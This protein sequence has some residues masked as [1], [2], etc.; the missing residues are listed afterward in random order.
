MKVLATGGAGYI[1][2][3]SVR[4]LLDSGHEVVVLDTLEKGHR[5]AVDP[6]ATFFE[7]SVGDAA[8]LD[9]A[10]RGCDAVLHMAG[11][12]EVAE[13]ERDP[14]RY[15]RN[16]VSEPL[17]MLDVMRR[18][19]ILRLVF[20]STAAVYGE[21]DTVPIPE[22]AALAPVNAYGLSK[23]MFEQALDCY[24]R[25]YGLKSIRLRYFNVAGSA[26]DG[27]LGEAHRP[28]SHII[29]KILGS[30]AA[31]ECRFEV[32][33]NDY[34][35]RDGTCVRDYIH[36]CDLALAHR[37]ALEAVCGPDSSSLLHEDV[38]F[39]GVQPRQRERLQQPRGRSS[40]FR[41]HRSGSRRRLWSSPSRRSGH[42]R[43]LARSR[44]RRARLDTGAARP[45]NDSRR[46]L[47]LAFTSPGRIR[48]LGGYAGLS[49]TLEYPSPP[50][51]HTGD[52]LRGRA[53]P[54]H[55]RGRWFKSN[56]AHQ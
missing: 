53:L 42:T 4:D 41:S 1:G 21:P 46:R 40:V 49:R 33:G 43:R 10:L 11:Y 18:H 48:T 34:P 47:A 25:A 39:G 28:E 6:R 23:L 31:G 38:T 3:I 26:A 12:A 30:I 24:G 15:L 5:A 51:G 35:T 2:S 16:N 55:G 9:V 54:S 52:W 44:P 50:C 45:V 8:I 17:I 14:A 20:S 56:I 27:S 37:L 32:Y 22:S 19:G 29:P 7:G 13:S 36:V